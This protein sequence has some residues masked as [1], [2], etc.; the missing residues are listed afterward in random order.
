MSAVLD[1]GLVLVDLRVSPLLPPSILDL[2][3]FLEATAILLEGMEV[4]TPTVTDEPT[5]PTTVHGLVEPVAIQITQV[6]TEIEA[7]TQLDQPLE[8]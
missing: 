1:L 2:S 6:T 3:V 8:A 7:L 5:N 4:A